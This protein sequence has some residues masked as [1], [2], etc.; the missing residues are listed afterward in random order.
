VLLSVATAVVHEASKVQG[1][2]HDTTRQMIGPTHAVAWL[3]WPY[4]KRVQPALRLPQLPL[5]HPHG[6]PEQLP[7]HR[8]LEPQLH[9]PQGALQSM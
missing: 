1:G 3:H 7:L 6:V 9:P 4:R 8:P 5:A 2:R